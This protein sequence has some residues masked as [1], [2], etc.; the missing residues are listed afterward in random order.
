MNNKQPSNRN[1]RRQQVRRK[2]QYLH[3]EIKTLQDGI[4]RTRVLINLSKNWWIQISKKIESKEEELN[5]F[6]VA[7]LEI[8]GLW[9]N[10]YTLMKK[11]MILDFYRKAWPN[12]LIV[13]WTLNGRKINSA[14]EKYEPLKMLDER[15]NDKTNTMSVWK[16]I[17]ARKECLESEKLH[18]KRGRGGGRF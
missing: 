14:E 13:T 3:K 7:E 16:G 11:I 5:G 17:T 10:S 8:K 18:I 12:N 6:L 9:Q 4:Q 2:L 15:K 1:S